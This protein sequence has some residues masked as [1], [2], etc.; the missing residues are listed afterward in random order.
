M[1][2]VVVFLVDQIHALLLGLVV[3]VL[4]MQHIAQGIGLP[5]GGKIAQLRLIGKQQRDTPEVNDRAHG[6][7]LHR[8]AGRN[9]RR[10]G[11]DVKLDAADVSAV[12]DQPH[13]TEDQPEPRRNK[14]HQ[15]RQ[16]LK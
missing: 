10:A 16:P 11:A 4:Q 3:L 8:A 14:K 12:L 9:G 1:L 13:Q 6:V 7:D 2:Q 5:L 15:R